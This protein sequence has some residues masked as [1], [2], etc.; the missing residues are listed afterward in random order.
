MSYVG[1][2]YGCEQLTSFLLVL[3][4]SEGPLFLGRQ[5]ILLT[6]TCREGKVLDIRRFFF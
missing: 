5:G 2:C 6:V 1:S 4:G 3:H